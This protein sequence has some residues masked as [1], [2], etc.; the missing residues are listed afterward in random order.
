LSLATPTVNVKGEE[1]KPD[2]A[3]VLDLIG[4][5]AGTPRPTSWGWSAG[6]RR[7]ARRQKN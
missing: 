7:A 5:P 2:K 1:G 6:R 3:R 4:Q